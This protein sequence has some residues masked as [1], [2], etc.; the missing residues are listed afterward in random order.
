MGTLHLR[1]KRFFGP[2][3]CFLGSNMT[4]AVCAATVKPEKPVIL[5]ID[6]DRS[7]LR[8]LKRVLEKSGFAVLSATTANVGLRL[9]REI[10]I[11]LVLIDQRLGATELTGAQLAREVK[12]V[13]PAVP[14]VLRSGY[15]P[16]ESIGSWDCFV[17]KDEPVENFLSILSDLIKRSGE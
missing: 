1:H 5:C 15:P 12:A 11:S 10:P 8:L 4:T 16:P 14:V 9:F 7:E 3:R 2:R 13:K 17:N 6:D